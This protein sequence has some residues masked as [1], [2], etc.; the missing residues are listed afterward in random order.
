MQANRRG[1]LKQKKQEK[2]RNKLRW[3]PSSALLVADRNRVRGFGQRLSM[4]GCPRRR[5][6]SCA[7]RTSMKSLQRCLRAQVG[8]DGGVQVHSSLLNV[9]SARLEVPHRLG[10]VVGSSSI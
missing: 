5:D 10:W 1:L 3:K 4:K 7:R 8:I 6:L 2:T 9:S